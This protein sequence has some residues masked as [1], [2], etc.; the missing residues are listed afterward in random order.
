VGATI[1]DR[2]Q[3][4]V[5]R[6]RAADRNGEGD[7]YQR[8]SINSRPAESVPALCKRWFL[9]VEPNWPLGLDASLRNQMIGQ[10]LILNVEFHRADLGAGPMAEGDKYLAM[11]LELLGRA[12]KEPNPEKRAGLESLA[13]SYRSRAEQIRASALIVEF[14]L[15]PETDGS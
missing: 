13:E 6:E 12:E 7:Y 4:L 2:W 9:P 8:R 15:P 11:A 3:P 1:R 5:L 10:P 14:N